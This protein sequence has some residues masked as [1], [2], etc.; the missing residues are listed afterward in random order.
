MLGFCEVRQAIVLD[1]VLGRTGHEMLWLATANL[2]PLWF[3][4]WRK[5]AA[6]REVADRSTK[7][8][9]KTNT[10]LWKRSVYF[11]HKLLVTLLVWQKFEHPLLARKL[12]IGNKTT[13]FASYIYIYIYIYIY[14]YIY[15]Q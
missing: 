14:T 2:T 6:L 8:I 5:E 10:A 9:V 15:I 3:S 11:G 12:T 13:C 4:Q 1:I 7:L